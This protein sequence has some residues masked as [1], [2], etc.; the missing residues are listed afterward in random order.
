MQTYI[1]DDTDS[2]SG[3]YNLYSL[4]S[5]VRHSCCANTVYSIH[6]N[7]VI[8]VRAAKDIEPGEQVIN[9]VFP[10]L[11]T[12]EIKICLMKYFADNF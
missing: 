4:L 12:C 6:K 1:S 9:F 2:V 5:L 8:A 7:G 10:L 3:V 11:V